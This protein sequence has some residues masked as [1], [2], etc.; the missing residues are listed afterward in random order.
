MLFSSHWYTFGDCSL[1]HA[2]AMLAQ[3]SKKVHPSGSVKQPHRSVPVTTNHFPAHFLVTLTP[4]TYQQPP[5]DAN[6]LPEPPHTYPNEATHFFPAFFTAS[7]ARRRDLSS[8]MRVVPV[9]PDSVALRADSSRGYG[10]VRA[11][12]FR[13]LHTYTYTHTRC[14]F[15]YYM[16]TP[17]ASTRSF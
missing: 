9:A 10:S 3:F 2:T 8:E 14:A 1:I 6:N 7:H 16:D 5:N 4:P 15:Q 17:A 12:S 13:G 11:D